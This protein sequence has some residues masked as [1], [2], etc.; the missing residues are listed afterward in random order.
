[1]KGDFTRDIFDP[2]KHYSQV[3]MQQGRVLVNDDWNAQTAIHVHYLRALAKDLIGQH[4][5]PFEGNGFAIAA[6]GGTLGPFTIGKGHYYVDGILCENDRDTAAYRNQLYLPT[7]EQP[8]DGT[9]LAYLDVWERHA[10]ADDDEVLREVALGGPDTTTRAQIVWQVKLYKLA[11]ALSADPTKELEEIWSKIRPGPTPMLSAEAFADDPAQGPCT[12]SPDARY[13]G[14]ENQLY[15]VEIHKGGRGSAD[16]TTRATFKWSRDNGSVVFPIQTPFTGD[17]TLTRQG[18]DDRSSLSKGQWVELIHDDSELMAINDHPLVQVV[19]VDDD[20]RVTLSGSPGTN[21]DFT[22]LIRPM[23]R[24]WDQ[25]DT[26]G[27]L[28]TGDIA[29]EEGKAIDLEDGVRIKFQPGGW[30]HPG[31]YWLIPA[32]VETGD[33]EWP[34]PGTPTGQTFRE[35]RGVDHHFAPLAEITMAGGK[36]TGTVVDHR[37]RFMSLCTLTKLQSKL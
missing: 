10:T 24:R 32:R 31:M 12:I 21:V 30:Y 9:Y 33:V 23:L 5:G 18:H 8:G 25:T 28:S 36:V 20:L 11:Q 3:L 37:C 14:V 15:R 2:R 1:V 16:E 26:N 27:L 19:D 35:P 17:F 22:K 29:V 7:Q 4:G 6:G 13:R 34:P